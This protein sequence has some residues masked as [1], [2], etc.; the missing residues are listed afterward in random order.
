MKENKFPPLPN[1]D[2]VDIRSLRVFM[3]VVRNR[4]FSAAKDE[5]NLNQPAISSYMSQLESRLKLTLCQRGRG[6]FQLTEQGE[7]VY[8]SARYL[9]SAIESFRA[10]VAGC[11]GQMVG[12]L[13]IG[14]VDVLA[15]CQSF[16]LPEVLSELGRQAPE[17]NI[18]LHKSDPRKLLKMLQEEQIHA[19][20]TPIYKA[21]D[22]IEHFNIFDEYQVMYCGKNHPFFAVPDDELTLELLRETKYAARD[23]TQDWTPPPS[24]YLKTASLTGDIECIATL[25]LSGNY[26]GYLPQ[27]YA[28]LWV[29]MGVMKPLL[30]EETAYH[31]NLQLA[32]RRANK[33]LA[34]ELLVEL[35]KKTYEL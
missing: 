17:V 10:D 30:I 23:Y 32:Y 18:Q 8:A 13:H 7:Q 33:N 29:K 25:I 14:M 16:K 1:L 31:C 6:G 9:F 34:V 12:E 28:E 5:L 24:P 19:A 11:R 3:A 22:S 26:V 35:M 27:H 15:T 2:N 21:P 20:V 4:G